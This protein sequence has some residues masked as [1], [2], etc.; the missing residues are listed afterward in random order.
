MMNQFGQPMMQQQPMGMG[1]GMQQPMMGGMQQPGMMGGMGQQQMM[2]GYPQQQQMMG[3]GFGQQQ[4]PQ[5][6]CN[7]NHAMQW[8][9]DNPYPG[10]VAVSCDVCSRDIAVA[11][12]FHHCPSCQSDFCQ[13]CGKARTR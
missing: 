7:N 1:M 4:K 5:T 11:Y 2:G 6:Y 10:S 8:K 13:Q 12:W 3:G 9:N